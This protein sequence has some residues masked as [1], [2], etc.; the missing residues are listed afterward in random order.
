MEALR[1]SLQISDKQGGE[2]V[3]V[4]WTAELRA[5]LGAGDLARYLEDVNTAIG[6]GEQ[7]GTTF[8][9]AAAKQ[10][11]IDQILQHGADALASAASDLDLDLD[12]LRE[13]HVWLRYG[14]GG[15]GLPLGGS[16][17]SIEIVADA[18]VPHLLGNPLRLAHAQYSNPLS[19]EFVSPHGGFLV[20]GAVMVARFVRDW[21]NKRKGGAAKVRRDE[22]E[23]DMATAQAELFRWAVDEVR[24]GRV[25]VPPGE[26]IKMITSND[27]QT[28]SR[29]SETPT[30]L[31][32][33]STDGADTH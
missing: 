31:R 6:V 26:V 7:W 3:R 9:R 33:P 19:L 15:R 17:R 25:H 28:L 8:A 5:P 27:M 23:A 20:M 13:L 16:R 2:A 22:A 24:S 11:L 30:Y 29:L 18:S 21:S 10:D 32:G 12:E 14:K 4:F 1:K